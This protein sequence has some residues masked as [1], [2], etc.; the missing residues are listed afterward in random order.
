M[1]DNVATGGGDSLN[2]SFGGGSLGAGGI[3]STSASSG[4]GGMG[5]SVPNGVSENGGD[6]R[7]RHNGAISLWRPNRR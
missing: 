3:N 6:L 7:A 2:A 5:G 1:L 4:R